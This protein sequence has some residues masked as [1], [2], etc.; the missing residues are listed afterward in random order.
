MD[1]FQTAGLTD[2]QKRTIQK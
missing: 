2:I 1:D